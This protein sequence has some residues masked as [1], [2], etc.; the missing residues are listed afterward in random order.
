VST[1]A[2]KVQFFQVDGTSSRGFGGTGLGL[3][4]SAR[5]VPRIGGSMVV[6]SA[7]GEG[8][9]SPSTPAWTWTSPQH[10]PLLRPIRRR[11][12]KR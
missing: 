6:G 4:I 1:Y 11:A 2:G 3:A 12:G 9:H 8:R 5:L 10:P 7:P